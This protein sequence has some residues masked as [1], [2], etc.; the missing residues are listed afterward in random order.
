[1]RL[2]VIRSLVAQRK[3]II[4]DLGYEKYRS[5]LIGSNTRFRLIRKKLMFKMLFKKNIYALNICFL[6]YLYAFYGI[7]M[8]FMLFICFLCYLY[9]FYAIYMLFMLFI[10][11]LQTSTDLLQTNTN[12]EIII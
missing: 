9:A 2:I 8:L 3:R 6:C 1:M 4:S 10:C 12:N 7:Y 11:S 5:E